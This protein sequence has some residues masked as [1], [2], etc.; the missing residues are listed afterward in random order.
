MSGASVDRGAILLDLSADERR[1][2]ADLAGSTAR[3]LVDPDDAAR[4]RLLPDGYRD[5]PDAA[6]EFARYTR[7]DVRRGKLDRIRSLLARLEDPAG[8]IRLERD[9]ADAW[10]RTLTDVRVALAERAGIREDGDVPEEPETAVVYEWLGALQWRLVES[11]DRLERR[12]RDGR[13][14]RSG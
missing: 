8:R 6:A 14:Y 4:A 10:A 12:G 5:D 3:A 13:R 2:L 11:L 7:D 9:D 1:V